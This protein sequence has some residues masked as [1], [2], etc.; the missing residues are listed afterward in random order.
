MYE[1]HE[2]NI[3]ASMPNPKLKSSVNIKNKKISNSFGIGLCI[4]SLGDYYKVNDSLSNCG[5]SFSPIEFKNT[6]GFHNGQF[7]IYWKLCIKK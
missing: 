1:Y 3:I 4:S 5:N 7:I 6:L 2:N